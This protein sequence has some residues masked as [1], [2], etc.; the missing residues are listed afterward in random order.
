MRPE[1]RLPG[2]SRTRC[3]ARKLSS[4]SWAPPKPSPLT[5]PTA[6]L[7]RPSILSPTTKKSLSTVE[8][9]RATLT[10]HVTGMW[11]DSTVLLDGAGEKARIEV[12]LRASLSIRPCEAAESCRRGVRPSGTLS[13]HPR[14]S[15][16]RTWTENGSSADAGLAGRSMSLGLSGFFRIR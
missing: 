14:L 6:A 16:R 7:S 5:R 11:Q 10:C 8:L 12:K 1:H 15:T 4:H 9:R 3:L 13:K 2:E